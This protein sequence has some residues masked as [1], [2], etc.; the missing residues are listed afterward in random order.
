[1]VLVDRPQSVQSVIF[2]GGLALQRKHA[3][4]VPLMVANEVLGG[5]AASRLF[6]DLREK[7]G[8]TYGAYSTV[9]EK[10]DVA[11]F[12]VYVAV[13]NEA[14]GEALAALFDHLDRITGKAASK[15]EL[16][17]ARRYLVDSFPLLID[18]PAK[19]AD[20]LSD[21][22][23]FG[24]PDDYWD[25]YRSA[26][27]GVTAEQA[28]AAA[29]KYIRPEQELIVVVGKAAEI[30]QELGKYGPVTVVDSEGKLILKPQGKE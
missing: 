11:P 17:D 30:A 13:R 14:T 12:R 9:Y 19:I 8:L 7:R 3:D 4:W 20:L 28:L 16:S 15:K 29:G 10:V 22:R 27:S 21:L 6:M 26:I 24:L 23:V 5:S 25:G 2:L 18:T 1:V